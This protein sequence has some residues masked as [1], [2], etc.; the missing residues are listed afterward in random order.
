MTRLVQT[1][2]VI[3]VLLVVASMGGCGNDIFAPPDDKVTVLNATQDTVAFEILSADR[4]ALVDPNPNPPRRSD[5]DGSKIL[6]PGKSRRVPVSEI[7]GY[8]RNADFVIFSWRIRGDTIRYGP[9]VHWTAAEQR[10]SAYNLAIEEPV[11]ID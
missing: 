10:K 7:S 1:R 11:T 4:A 8:A 5:F 2:W 6:A 3:G 9:T